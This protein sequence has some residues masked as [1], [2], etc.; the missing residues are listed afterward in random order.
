MR[1]LPPYSTSSSCDSATPVPL[2]YRRTDRPSLRL[3]HVCVPAVAD[4]AV[5]RRLRVRCDTISAPLP[6]RTRH[7]RAPRSSR[8][9]RR[10][11]R[12]RSDSSN[13]RE[14]PHRQA[15]S[16]SYSCPEYPVQCNTYK[17]TENE[18]EYIFQVPIL[19]PPVIERID[20]F[21]KERRTLPTN[22]YFGPTPNHLS[23][24]KITREH[25]QVGASC[26]DRTVS[27]DANFVGSQKSRDIRKRR[28]PNIEQLLFKTSQNR[29]LPQIP[30]VDMNK[31][32]DNEKNFASNSSIDSK[33]NTAQKNEA[34]SF[35]YHGYDS[36]GSD[37]ETTI[38]I[39]I[40]KQHSLDQL[41]SDTCKIESTN[42]V[43]QISEN[44]QTTVY[45]YKYN[46]K[47]FLSLDLRTSYE[48]GE[49]PIQSQSLD[50]SKTIEKDNSSKLQNPLEVINLKQQLEN[51]I[52]RR[53]S[54]SCVTMKSSTIILN[55]T[56]DKTEDI[57][58]MV[59]TK[60]ISEPPQNQTDN[61]DKFS[62][63]HVNVVSINEIPTFQEYRSPNSNSP[64]SSIDLSCKKPLPS[65][66]KNA[67]SRSYSVAA[68]NHIDR[69]FSFV[70]NYF[71]IALSPPN[72][73]SN[74]RALTPDAS[75]L[76]LDDHHNTLDAM[77]ETLSVGQP[78]P[79]LD[80]PEPQN[81]RQS[82]R[83]L[84]TTPARDKP[85]TRRDSKRS[86]DYGGRENGRNNNQPQPL[87]RRESRRGQFTRSLSNADVPPDEKAGNIMHITTQTHIPPYCFE[88]AN[89]TELNI[90]NRFL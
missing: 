30:S 57:F 22:I 49:I 41:K 3:P 42:K 47:K 88:C 53:N 34:K 1:I 66:I 40:E 60:S 37:T 21:H 81:P 73:G 28:L 79:V 23:Y 15:Y 83:K 18:R 25:R 65:I 7:A 43:K 82:N 68:T 29:S 44:D 84:P 33:A 48:G 24:K 85:V 31:V 72:L 45:E 59:S 38:H 12:S 55:P 6:H 4:R 52:R 87:E 11:L 75:H 39:S 61:E 76:P 27:L 32:T 13:T 56:P 80:E 9:L 19:Q 90:Q 46:R 89:L 78:S 58:K 26:N 10:I 20:P 14:C 54:E 50:L 69:E 62:K 64:Q 36:G 74:R 51:S 86:N 16:R 5:R 17:I 77:A 35:E 71:S 67:R 2:S 63:K 8:H 70:A